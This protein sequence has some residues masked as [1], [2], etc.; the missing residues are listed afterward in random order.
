MLEQ[1]LES[2]PHEWFEPTRQ[3]SSWVPERRPLLFGKSRPLAQ[4]R[5]SGELA[6]SSAAGEGRPAAQRSGIG[7]ETD[8]GDGAGRTGP[9]G[10]PLIVLGMHRSGT[11][12][13]AGALSILGVELGGPLMAPR[14]GENI[15]GYF[16]HL[17]IYRFHRRLLETLGLSWDDL[18][19]P[20][21]EPAGNPLFADLCTELAALLSRHFAG[22]L[23]WAVKD[24]RACRF[25]P[26]WDTALTELGC[27][28]RYLIVFR[29]PDE[30]AASLARRDHFSRD[31]SD[32][33]WADHYLSAEA[34][35][36][37]APRAFMSYAELLRTPE[38]ELTRVA[39]EIGI[40]WPTG[41]VGTASDELRE[42]LSGRLRH[43]VAPVSGLT[44]RGR[45]GTIVPRLSSTLDAAATTAVLD[46]T[47]C[48]SLRG[49]LDEVR[50]HFDP[51]LV[52]H[53]SQ[54]AVRSALAV[55][56]DLG[57]KVSDL[58]RLLAK[59]TDWMRVQD[60]ELESQRD[61]LRSI[62]EQLDERT[63]WLQ[64]QDEI[65]HRQ[66]D[67]IDALER[68]QEPLGEGPDEAS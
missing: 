67:R 34:A 50:E 40:K 49:E 36:R 52:E 28:P 62:E 54:L 32:L 44:P 19:T 45:L 56:D 1:N 66:I 15:R 13:L 20:R 58:E 37:G 4:L 47:A 33:L 18:R 21:L 42:F 39:G 53:F 64:I 12:A 65:L 38:S 25:I 43:H 27:T 9:V 46:E 60:G 57:R 26:L 61:S 22:A 24:P 3:P 17:E 30:V 48:E 2:T 16:E 7:A 59:R 14:D 31:K 63:R 11:S 10:D 68:I 23:L 55:R 51:L 6:H 8:V 5:L 41:S 29:H 35:T